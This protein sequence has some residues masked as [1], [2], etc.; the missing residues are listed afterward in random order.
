MKITERTHTVLNVNSTDFGELSKKLAEVWKAMPEKDKLVSLVVIGKSFG[1][2]FVILFSCLRI[3][4]AA[5]N[6][7]CV[8]CFFSCTGLEAESSIFAAQTEQSGGHN[9]QTQELQ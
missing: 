2:Y 1:I 3:C 6:A 7:W 8:F 4:A 9:R 5:L